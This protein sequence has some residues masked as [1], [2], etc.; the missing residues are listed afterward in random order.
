MALVA[1]VGVNDADYPVTK[2]EL[3]KGKRVQ[4]W[5]CPYYS[6]WK[7]MLHR[8]YGKAY[9]SYE[10]ATVCKEWLH[11]S[12]FEQWLMEQK[13]NSALMFY[14][15][16]KDLLGKGSSLYSPESCVLISAWLNSTLTMRDSS[17]GD[18]P[19][20]VDFMAEKGKYR[21]QI[22]VF[23]KKKHNGVFETAHEAH[24]AWQKEK[25]KMFEEYLAHQP[26][27]DYRVFDGVCRV[28]NNLK[29]DIKHNLETKSL[30]EE[31]KIV[32]R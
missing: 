6:M 23:G 2:N 32:Q 27:E 1:G 25:I 19:V 20:G 11:F 26:A 28:I 8:C 13:R 22:S 17:R 31:R 29:F 18:Y 30:F 16:D 5:V 12:N 3:R 15:L 7:S 14:A 9:K 10:K 24:V 4:T 21:S